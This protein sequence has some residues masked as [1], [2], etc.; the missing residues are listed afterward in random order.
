M[1]PDLRAALRAFLSHELGSGLQAF[2][3]GVYL[4][5]RVSSA[6]PPAPGLLDGAGEGLVTEPLEIARF[7]ARA[8]AILQV[9]AEQEGLQVWKVHVNRQPASLASRILPGGIGVAPDPAAR[10]TP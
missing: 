3:P 4:D 10:M 1:P 5:L 7:P 6:D 8:L 2:A 9:H